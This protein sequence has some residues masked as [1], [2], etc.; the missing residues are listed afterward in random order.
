MK[1]LSKVAVFALALLSLGALAQEF[2][3]KPLRLIV[4]YPPG[5]STDILG[6]LVAQ[7]VSASVGQPIVVENRGGASGTI[8]S[9]YVAKQPGDGYT[10]M[11]GTDATHTTNSYLSKDFPY[12]PIRDFTPLTA[13]AGNV[14]I[15]VVPPS[16]PVHTVKEL[17]DYAKKNPGKLAFGSSGAGSPHHLA[18]EL[19]GQMTGTQ[20]VHIAYKGGGPAV[21]DALGGQIPM[22][23]AS[24][25]SV[26]P[27]IQSG[28]LRAI[29]VTDSRR[30][31]GL[32]DVPAI[33]E[34]VPGFEMTSWLG[35]FAPAH[36]PQPIVKRLNQEIVKALNAP[37]SRS[38]MDAAGLVVIGNT[39]EEFA[40]MVRSD[41]EKRGKLIRAAGIKGE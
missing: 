22:L 1:L 24:L 2:P 11:I 19:L 30:Y 13:A 17:I 9:A 31:P 41:Y 12:D 15:L 16:F 39:P 35:F 34:T 27:Y 4:P 29:A 3:S 23:F 21:T 26:M 6:R 37:D 14:I 25:V 40:A 10:F 7:K 8:G 33:A 18:G 36:V 5:A 20:L 28:K 32:P 38:K